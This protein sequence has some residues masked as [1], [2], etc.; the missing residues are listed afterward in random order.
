MSDNHSFVYSH[1]LSNT[2]KWSVPLKANIDIPGILDQK[3]TDRTKD[4]HVQFAGNGLGLPSQIKPLVQLTQYCLPW[5]P[6]FPSDPNS[7][8][9]GWDWWELCLQMLMNRIISWWVC[10][11]QNSVCQSTLFHDIKSRCPDLLLRIFKPEIPETESSN[12]KPGALPLDIESYIM[13]VPSIQHDCPLRGS[14][15]A[16]SFPLVSNQDSLAGDGRD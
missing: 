16:V 5:Q 14:S 12:C 15:E 13:M 6:Q 9:S 1:K 7:I 4:T 2:D 3:G 10:H 8:H 11:A